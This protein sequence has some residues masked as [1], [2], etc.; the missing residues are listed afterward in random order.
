VL[1][2][3]WNMSHWQKSVQERADAWQWLEGTGADI[4]LVQ[5]A[6]PP[7]SLSKVVY[8]EIG[9]GRPWGSAVVGFSCAVTA[10][11]ECKGRYNS[12]PVDLH[13]TVPGSVA[14]AS[15]VVE[16]RTMTFVSMYGVIEDGYADT[17][18]NRQLSDLVPLFDN[19]SA[20]EALLL[21][22]DLNITTQWVGGQTRY[23]AWEAVTLQRL[24]AFGLRDVLDRLRPD[25]PLEGCDCLDEICRHIHTQR[26]ARSA[27]PWQNDYV[28][29]S[30]GLLAGS[31]LK[32][33]EV[34]DDEGLRRLSGHMPMLVELDL[35]D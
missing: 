25:G 31:R 5:E 3:L 17:T 20:S 21:G 15:A 1:I 10:I 28:F 22:G 9:N 19:P 13:R 32:R 23:R 29:A 6:V 27:R 14:V 4:A 7:S 33:A 11:T 12:Q 18:V 34:V 35:G 2:A 16:G 8:K 26:H 24:S 30:E